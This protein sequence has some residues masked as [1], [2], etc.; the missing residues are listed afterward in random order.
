M[1]TIP[2]PSVL[3]HVLGSHAARRCGGA[4]LV[5]SGFF[6]TK[7]PYVPQSRLLCQGGC[8][9]STNSDPRSIEGRSRKPCGV[10]ID[11]PEFRKRQVNRPETLSSCRAIDSCGAN[12]QGTPH[13]GTG[14][15]GRAE[16][17]QEPRLS[18]ANVHCQILSSV[19]PST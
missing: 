11:P 7:R 8:P 3:A 4:T 19:W 15:E 1:E 10:R 16:I 13:I 2:A 17:T 6:R 18:R 12:G 9:T 5:W 14:V